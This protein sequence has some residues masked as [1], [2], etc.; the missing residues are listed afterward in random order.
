MSEQIEKA[1]AELPFPAMPLYVRD[2][3]AGRA[4]RT[5]TPEQRGAFIQ[6]LCDAWADPVAPCSLPDSDVEL[7][8]LSGLFTRWPDVGAKVRGQF[9]TPD[10]M[11]ALGFEVPDDGRLRNVKQWH[12]YRATLEHRAKKADSG[13]RAMTKRWGATRT[14]W[15][16]PYAEAWREQYQ[17][18]MSIGPA[19]RPLSKLRE[20][21]GEEETLKR[22]RH[23]LAATEALYANAA[24]FAATFGMW[25]KANGGGKSFDLARARE[26]WAFYNDNGYTRAPELWE[27]ANRGDAL[28]TELEKVKPWQ[29]A[30]TARDGQAAIA[31]VA[32][33]LAA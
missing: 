11:L 32:R 1:T 29:I 16:T 20:T 28:V 12:V 33:R 10:E 8:V 22:W 14:T 2:W 27:K 24:R 17:G 21:H 9:K 19:T 31:E 5:M 3:L 18:D 30:R 6:L 4:V 15:M 26:R 25:D 13:R 7:A 23:Y